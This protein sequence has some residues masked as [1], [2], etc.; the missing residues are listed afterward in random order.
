MAG[1]LLQPPNAF[2]FDK[3][4]EW[5]RWKGRFQQYRIASGLSTES[6]ERQ[7]STLLYCM[8]EASEDILNMSGISNEDKKVFDSVI[9]R[10]DAHFKVR[11]NVIFERACFNRRQQ[12]KGESIELF[13]TSLHQAA[14]NCE[15]GAIKDEMIRDRLVVGIQDQSLS[16][17]LQMEA[18]LTLEKAKKLVRQ[19]EAVKQ[20][21]AHLKGTASDQ[22][23]LEEVKTRYIPKNKRFTKP[24]SKAQ[25]CQRC[26]KSPHSFQ[27]CPA[28]D[29][30]CFKCDRKGHYGSQC[31]SKGVAEITEN[32]SVR[33]PDPDSDE[34][35]LDSAQTGETGKAWKLQVTVNSIPVTFKVDTGAEVTAVSE[36]TW[37]SMPQTPTLQKATKT[38]CGPDCKPLTLLG[39]TEVHLQVQ[40]RKC[41]QK[42]FVVENLRN[43][44]LGL[45]AIRALQVLEQVG[46]IQDDSVV[47]QYPEIF[48]GLGTFKTDYTIRLKPDATPFAIYVPRRVALPQR[49]EVEKELQ[50]MQ[51]L[52]VIS[53]VS[54]PTPWCAG[55][56]IV[57]KPSGKLHVCVD[58]KPLNENVMREVHPL[59]KVDSTLAQMAGAKVFTKLDTNSGFWQVPLSQESRLLT[60]FLTPIGR[61]CFNKLPF[62]INSAPE[63]FQRKMNELLADIPGVLVHVDDIL[64]FAATRDVH[65]Q[66]L[67]EVLK[68]IQNEGLTLN[69]AK[70][71]FH[72]S[73]I[74]YLGHIIDS[75]G[76]S[77][78]PKRTEAIRKMPPPASLTELRRFMGIVNQLNK[79]SPKIAELSQPLR[80][81]L[82]PKQPYTWTPSQ[83]DAFQKLQEEI[84]SNRVLALYDL[85]KPTKISAD[86]SAYGLGAVLLQQNDKEWRPVAF[87]SRALTETETRY[88]QIEKEA[89]ALT[90]ACEKFAEY[91]LGK[92]F[93]LETDHKPLVPILGQKSLDTLPP[94]VLRFRIRL[95]RFDYTIYHS[96]GKSLYL[97][98]TLSRAPI[99]TL[100]QKSDMDAEKETENL[101]D[102]VI[103]SLPAEEASLETYRHA[104]SEDP[105]CSKIIEFCKSGWPNRNQL[106]GEV[107]KYY[108]VR[109]SLTY[110]RHLLLY[111]SRIVIPEKLRKETMEKI[112]SGH[113]GIVRCRLR[114]AQSVWWPGASKTME[115]F[116]TH[117]PECQK[118]TAPHREPLMP[119]KLPSYPWEKVGTDLFEIDKTTYLIV[120]D[121]FSRFIEVQKLSNT[122]ASGVITALK[123]IFAR[124]GIPSIMISDNGPQYN[125]KEMREFAGKYNFCHITSSPYHPQSNGLAE[126]SVKTAKLLLKDS[127]DPCKAL[128]SYRAT[129]LPSCGFSPAELLMGRK[130]RTDVPQIQSTFVPK[131][132]YLKE[133]KET[134]E[135]NKH[136]QKR[137]Y[138]QRHRARPLMPL[139]EHT[140]VWVDT[141]HGQVPG[142]IVTTS[143]QPRSY[144]VD[145]PSGEVRRNRVQLRL[146]G[147]TETNETD[148][149][150]VPT[151]RN[152]R[153]KTGSAPGPPDYLRC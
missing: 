127:P 153:S 37:K 60:T 73:K 98:D 30:V 85:E 26:G 7:V 55:M 53:K 144:Q 87:A 110:T 45:P 2:S 121:Y 124:H 108:Q 64:I 62:G 113:Q 123:A 49:P 126:R 70:C 99:N 13:I 114:V 67:H 15:Y 150:P 50:R 117:C 24:Q 3:P 28:R 6:G 57:T 1:S 14:D 8:G 39:E 18:D 42:I 149:P 140:P 25:T 82:S 142:S 44:L 93:E 54:E 122:T 9:A 86:A 146:R 120:V 90:W 139:P 78:D 118:N 79:F 103:T 16:E 27:R 95:M 111:G 36:N 128:L 66:R 20:Q 152:T 56:V 119:S 29:A 80:K 102:S 48:K 89:L 17:R 132:S 22:S 92:R 19:R 46:E 38:L 23:G 130:I 84:S 134:D 11:K 77:P 109:S 138:D 116:V 97:A 51:Q 94:R 135:K 43:N 83:D 10:Y 101:V 47:Q 32:M 71:K 107:S 105:T 133:F 72:Q 74:E 148:V 136:K 59:P 131:W 35:Y 63:Y 151:E 58:L 69:K 96:P 145:T 115:T 75:E 41:T 33:D 52:G 65:D 81:L 143:T 34:F 141:P 106:K 88:A 125:C 4:E 40:Q 21:A 112:H 5:S 31:L 76:I 100:P 147:E 104:Q 91:V 129:P 61:F 137:D 68:R 12:E